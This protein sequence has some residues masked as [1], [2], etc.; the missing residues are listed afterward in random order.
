[1]VF[2]TNPTA[3]PVV[4]INSYVTTAHVAGYAGSHGYPA[5][6]TEEAEIRPYIFRAMD[7]IESYRD[8]FQGVKTSQTQTLQ[9]PRVGVIVDNFEVAN[10]HIPI[11]VQEATAICA[12]EMC[13]NGYDPHR[14]LRPSRDARTA[15]SASVIGSNISERFLV[16]WGIADVL[17][18][19][20]ALLKPLLRDDVDDIV[21]RD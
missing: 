7:F 21:V 12:I 11:E 6:A 9:W 15:T 4:G 20:E 1:M 19:V 17:P 3:A 14:P 18:H 10:D 5:P 16:E 2:E 8:K 13:I